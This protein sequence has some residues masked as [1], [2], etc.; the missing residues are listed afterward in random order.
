[1]DF[2]SKEPSIT[3]ELFSFTHIT[4]ILITLV[5]PISIIRHKKELSNLSYKRKLSIGLG[6]FLLMLDFGFYIWKYAVGL[7]L[8]FPIPMHIC[9]WATYILS[10]ALIT[11]NKLFINLSVYYG[12]IGGLLSLLVPDFG[13]YGSNHFRF[14]QFFILHGILLIGPLLL[15]YFNKGVLQIKYL[16][17]TIIVMSIQ[18]M[19][20]YPINLLVERV[21][22]EPANMMFVMEP[23]AEVASILPGF[24]YY[25]FIVAVLFILVW[26]GLYKALKKHLH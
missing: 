20:A 10:I 1:M 17:I 4:I 22:N 19:I 14:Y 8:M 2:F 7:Q 26:F 25:I 13:G 21:T 6:V 23:P 24:P 9:S 16:F 11:N 15:L 3:F 5:I 12:F 18:A